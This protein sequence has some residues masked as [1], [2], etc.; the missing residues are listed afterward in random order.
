[1][2]PAEMRGRTSSGLMRLRGG[3]ESLHEES[4]FGELLA[5]LDEEVRVQDLAFMV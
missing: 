1:M 4:E 2:H 5:D 3:M